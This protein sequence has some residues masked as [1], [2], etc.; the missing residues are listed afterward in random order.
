MPKLPRSHRAWPSA[1]FAATLKAEL[2]SLDGGTLPLDQGVSCGGQVDDSDITAMVLRVSD[3]VSMVQA[4]V[5]IFFG[6]IVGGCSCGDDPQ[7]QN[8]YCEMRVQIDKRT[9]EALFSVIP[10]GA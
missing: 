9:A 6:E 2:Q 8:A 7:T 1:A 10:A 3:E 4:D 5:G